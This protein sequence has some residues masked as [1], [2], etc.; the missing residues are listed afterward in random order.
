MNG[1]QADRNRALCMH[2]ARLAREGM[3]TK[4]I[5]ERVGKRPE[6]I[7]AL[8]VTGERLLETQHDSREEG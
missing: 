5:A 4:R 2:I 6:Q 7:K 8:R 1:N 3:T